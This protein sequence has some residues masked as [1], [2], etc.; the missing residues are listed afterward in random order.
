M[1]ELSKLLQN[2]VLETGREVQNLFLG[3]SRESLITK[4]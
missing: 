1:H 2:S 3:L 4:N